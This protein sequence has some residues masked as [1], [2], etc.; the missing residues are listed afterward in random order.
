MSRVKEPSSWA[1]LAAIAASL[2]PFLP[3]ELKPVAGLVAAISGALGVFL[4]ER[5]GQK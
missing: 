5:G 2:V 4:R 3:D 1:S